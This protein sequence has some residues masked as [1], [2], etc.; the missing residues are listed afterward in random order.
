MPTTARTLDRLTRTQR[1]GGW[2]VGCG[3]ALA[4]VVLL[5]IGVG[6]IIS[7]NWRDW[8]SDAMRGAS[9]AIID[10]MPIEETEKIE[11]RAVV[12]DFV[13]RFRS[14][15]IS[16]EQ[17]MLVFQEISRS[18][19]IPAG[20]AI[21]ISHA[22]FEKSALDPAEKAEG[23]V[24]IGRIAQGLADQSIDPAILGDVLNPLKA[25][26]SDTNVIQFDIN[27]RKIRI[28]APGS[29]TDDEL[30]AFIDNA[31]TIADSNLLPPTPPPF[32]LSDEL[33]QA[34]RRA[35][36]E[37]GTPPGSD[38]VVPVPAELPPGEVGPTS[39]EAAPGLVEPEPSAP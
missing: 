15:D 11:A 8:S 7:M 16:T 34:I 18:P 30:R 19:V 26:A 17:L 29:T 14:G 12:T 3:I 39:T 37:T 36:G 21:G 35:L 28:K 6:V 23:Q 20:T 10:G 32:D 25:S 1:R 2:L 9:D 5:V 27:G 33:D 13:N 22:Y 4:V 38:G 31:R 24:Q